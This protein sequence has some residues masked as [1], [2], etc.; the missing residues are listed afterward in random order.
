MA[1]GTAARGQV[2]TSHQQ[3]VSAGSAQ[4]NW[5]TANSNLATVQSATEVLRPGATDDSSVIPILVP[6]GATRV[7]VRSARTTT[8]PTFTTHPIVQLWGIDDDGT[9]RPAVPT[10]PTYTAVPTRLDDTDSSADGITLTGTTSDASNSAGTAFYSDVSSN[11]GYDCLGCT[12]L[13]L[14]VKTAANYSTGTVSGLV[15]FLN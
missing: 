15:K 5:I 2:N 14:I 10:A 13:F 4:S 6:E 8:A 1:I 11:T 3:M 9:A 12:W 7:L